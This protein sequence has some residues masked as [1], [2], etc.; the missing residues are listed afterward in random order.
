MRRVICSVVVIA[1]VALLRISAS[2]AASSDHVSP[3]Y[4]YDG[5]AAPDQVLGP[6]HRHTLNETSA[7]PTGG[8]LACAGALNDDGSAILNSGNCSL[9]LSVQPFN[10]SSWRRGYAVLFNVTSY[11]RARETF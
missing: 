3:E 5:W 8:G 4:F 2:A 9:I 10:G 1:T 11:V 7:R 6:G